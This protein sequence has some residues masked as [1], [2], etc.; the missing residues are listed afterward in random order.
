MNI[1]SMFIHKKP[2][3]INVKGFF[4]YLHFLYY[5]KRFRLKKQDQLY[6]LG[7]A[8][9]D[10]SCVI[11]QKISQ[12]LFF[13]FTQPLKPLL[14]TYPF[15]LQMESFS[16]FASCSSSLNWSMYL[17]FGSYTYAT[18]ANPSFNNVS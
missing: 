7:V 17:V 11:Q 4:Y 14:V 1:G 3:H 5:S 10:I 9:S 16:D 12:A 13:Y 8:K 18:L 2:P 15:L 6:L